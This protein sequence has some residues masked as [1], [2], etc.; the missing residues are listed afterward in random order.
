[1]CYYFVE[2][3]DLLNGE[4]VDV[5]AVK[6]TKLKNQLRGNKDSDDNVFH[7]K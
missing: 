4:A 6:K 2:S 7:V 1:M 5:F 3:L